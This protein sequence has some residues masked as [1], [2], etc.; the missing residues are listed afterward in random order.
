[1]NISQ[2]EMADD[3]ISGQDGKIFRSYNMKTLKLIALVVFKK[4]K[5]VQLCNAWM[6]ACPFWPH[7]DVIS[8]VVVGQIGVDVH[9]KFGDS[10]SNRS[11][12]IRATH[13]AIAAD[14]GHG[15]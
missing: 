4:A 5:L 14:G 15:S 2:L 9:V 11:C 1:M 10:R 12:D 13:F 8:S 6:T 3:V 7:S